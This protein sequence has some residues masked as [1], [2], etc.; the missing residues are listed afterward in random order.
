M[1][2]LYSDAKSHI[3]DNTGEKAV[4]REMMPNLFLRVDGQK[5][6]SLDEPKETKDAYFLPW[7]LDQ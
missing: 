5:E 1:S 6:L 2:I 3:E 4:P 7:N